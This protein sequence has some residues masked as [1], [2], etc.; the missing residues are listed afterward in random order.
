[1]AEPSNINVE[2]EKN[3]IDSISTSSAIVKEAF[4]AWLI[5]GNAKKYLP[6]IC[7]TCID[8]VSNYLLRRKISSFDLWQY[9]DLDLFKKIYNKAINDDIFRASDR[10]TYDVFFH[11]GKI[12]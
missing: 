12:L 7:L 5:D 3:A 4:S 6:A 10:I 11:V 9:T 2:N 1:V 8:K